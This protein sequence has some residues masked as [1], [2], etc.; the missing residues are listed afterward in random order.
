MS[1]LAVTADILRGMVVGDEGGKTLFQMMT[2]KKPKPIDGEF[3]L[4]MRIPSRVDL[5]IT[6]YYLA[7]GKLEM[8]EPAVKGSIVQIGQIDRGDGMIDYVARIA[9]DQVIE[10]NNMTILLVETQRKKVLSAKLFTLAAEIYPADVS[11]WKVWIDPDIGLIGGQTLES[12]NGVQYTRMWGSGSRAKPFVSREVVYHDKFG[13]KT[14]RNHLMQMMYGRE[15]HDDSGNK[16]AD[17]YTLVSVVN[18]E[19]VEL[20]IGIPITI[21]EGKSI[22]GA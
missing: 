10:G 21:I 1:R 2:E 16:I 19:F 18:E 15:V 17:E 14:T 11:D 8:Y 22:I 20:L 3:P 5:D 7:E 9:P 12:P 6:D 4:N 13:V